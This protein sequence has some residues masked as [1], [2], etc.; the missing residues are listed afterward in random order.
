VRRY[1]QRGASVADPVLRSC[2]RP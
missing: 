1:E 2:A